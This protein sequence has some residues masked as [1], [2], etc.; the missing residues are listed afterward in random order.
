MDQFF[1]LEHSR[2][3]FE[4]RSCRPPGG[5]FW[6]RGFGV[7]WPCMIWATPC[8]AKPAVPRKSC[9]IFE[10]CN[11]QQAAAVLST[12]M[13]AQHGLCPV[14]ISTTPKPARPA[15]A[16][17]SVPE[18]DAAPA[19]RP[20][21]S[22]RGVARAREAPPGDH[23][24]RCGL[25][26]PCQRSLSAD[27]RS[28]GSGRSGC[29]SMGQRAAGSAPLRERLNGC[30]SAYRGQRTSTKPCNRPALGSRSSSVLEHGAFSLE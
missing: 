24:G 26:R 1:I 11:P 2:N 25:A 8:A 23:R 27:N 14:R 4:R 21:P 17:K 10:V 12:T 28:N 15:S 6:I 7:P 9:R 18:A 16:M 22:L 5:V 13:S 20:D 30:S 19:S 29:L 3:P